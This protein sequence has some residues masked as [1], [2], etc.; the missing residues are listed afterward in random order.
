MDSRRRTRRG[1]IV[2]RLIETFNRALKA[3]G[4]K[5]FEPGPLERA[6]DRAWPELKSRLTELPQGAPP[7]NSET[8]KRTDREILNDI[9]ETVRRL[10]REGKFSQT[11]AFGSLSALRRVTATLP[12]D[13]EEALKLAAMQAHEASRRVFELQEKVLEAQERIQDKRAQGNSSIK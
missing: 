9:L 13:P 3:S 11:S 8:S 7:Q 4:E 1:R 6:F 10:E 2:S 5:A 12:Q